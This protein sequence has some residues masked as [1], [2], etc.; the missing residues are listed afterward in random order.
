M[1]LK[2]DS[3]VT[4][5]GVL[6]VLTALA[7]VCSLILSAPVLGQQFA[8][9]PST[10]TGTGQVNIPGLEG[11]NGFVSGEN[12]ISLAT[13]M[14]SQDGDKLYFQVVGLAISNPDSPESTV[15]TM[16]KPLMGVLDRSANTIQID[17]SDIAS[18]V[19]TGGTIDKSTLYDALRANKDVF[20][21]DLSATYQD[22]ADNRI[23]FDVNSVTLV[24]PDGTQDLFSLDQPMQLVIDTVTYRMS[25][26]VFPELTN[27]MY[28]CYDNYVAG[29]YTE[30]LPV[31]VPV[32]VP[33][34]VPVLVPVYV[35]VPIPVA[36]CVGPLYG[37]LGGYGDYGG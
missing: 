5:K 19:G 6:S 32:I 31:A 36:P 34:A 20:V 16:N 14:A 22:T 9:A 35:P 11:L 21:I 27:D 28:D 30:V 1:E 15:Y 7:V 17:V 18:S 29:V 13:Y 12:Q 8:A 24:K 25:F 10:V 37:G 26:P 4:P 33:V 23:T 3:L 2:L